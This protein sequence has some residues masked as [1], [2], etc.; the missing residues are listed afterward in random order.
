MFLDISS[1]SELNSDL[2]KQKK[3]WKSTYK[4]LLE[5]DS[6]PVLNEPELVNEEDSISEQETSAEQTGLELIA[7][8]NAP[9]REQIKYHIYALIDLLVKRGIF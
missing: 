7:L 4:K 8:L 2:I 5:L 1:F 6:E 9:F 3:E